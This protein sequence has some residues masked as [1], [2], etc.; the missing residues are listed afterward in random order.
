MPVD[1]IEDPWGRRTP[2][3]SGEIWPSRVDEHVG[4]DESL[5]ERWVQSAS[6]MSSNGDAMDIAVSGGRLV[7][8]RGRAEDRINRGRLDPKDLFGWQANGS[9]DRLTR[10]LVRRDGRLVETDWDTAMNAVVDRS[11]ALLES[12]GPSALGF[13]TTGQLFAEEYYT[14]T[15]IAGRHRH[16]SSGWKHSAVHCDCG[17]GP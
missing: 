12:D 14:L 13:Y 4:V 17:R 11:K 2:F 3:G 15:T 10:P 9:S 5:I 8:V 1:R 6:V 7:G 16:E